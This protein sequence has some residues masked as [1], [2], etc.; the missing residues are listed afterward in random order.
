M[1][2]L[3]LL[4]LLL[5]LL[6]LLLSLLLLLLLLS[7]LLLLLPL[8]LLLLLPWLMR[9]GGGSMGGDGCCV[10]G[11]G[12]SG[13]ESGDEATTTDRSGRLE[14][15]RRQTRRVA[16]RPGGRDASNPMVGRAHGHA[17]LAAERAGAAGL[18][19]LR[20]LLLPLVNRVCASAA[21]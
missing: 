16:Q 3:S 20:L 7:L 17:M 12:E 11:S 9:D 10:A 19:V 15:S 8:L 13:G 5:S 4:L 1:P 14:R 2:L 18:L 21:L 6:L